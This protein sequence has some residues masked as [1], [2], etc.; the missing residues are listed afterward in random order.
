[1]A[2]LL[3]SY[4]SIFYLLKMCLYCCNP[5][6]V[7]FMMRIKGGYLFMQFAIKINCCKISNNC[8]SPHRCNNIKT[9]GGFQCRLYQ[10]QSIGAVTWSWD[11]PNSTKWSFLVQPPGT[12]KPKEGRMAE[13]VGIPVISES[14]LPL[15][16]PMQYAPFNRRTATS[17][18]V[19]SSVLWI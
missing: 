14:I 4:C 7:I 3:Q 19:V 1:M 8:L 9:N 18:A 11:Q 2:F 15:R 16:T 6:T 17:A 10:R 12:L 5:F 13:S